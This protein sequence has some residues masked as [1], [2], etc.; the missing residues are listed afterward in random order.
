MNHGWLGL[1]IFPLLA[2]VLSTDRRRIDLKFCLMALGLQ[3]IFC[4]IIHKVPLIQKGFLLI[5]QG[6]NQLK[7]ATL[8]GTQFV[9]GYLGGNA[10]PFEV[11]DTSKLFIFAFQALPMLMVISAL[12]ML[13]FYWGVLPAIVKGF[14]WALRRTLKIGGALG[15]CAA[16]KAFLG[17]TDAPLLIR[18]YLARLS[19][20]EL[21]SVMTAGMATTSA[22]AMPLYASLLEGH[23][24][25]PLI[26]ILAA[27]FISIP[28]ALLMSRLVI[29]ETQQETGGDLSEPYPFSSSMDALARGTQ[30]GLNLYLSLIA[31]LIVALAVVKLMNMVLGTLPA[32]GGKALSL[33]RIAGMLMAPLTWA[34]GIPW[35]ES[36]KAGELLGTK[37]MLNEIIAFINFDK[38][39]TLSGHSK[40]MMIYALCGFANLSSI[41]IQIAGLGTLAPCRR[42]EIIALA[43]KALVAGTLASCL[44]GTIVGLVLS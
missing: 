18:P 21:F 27:S 36:F 20:S 19:K 26:H 9:F 30:D 29:P 32:L 44:S 2:W 17:Q 25:N 6:I 39:D 37:A 22:T 11:K 8:E 23:I 12:S 1:L 7:I 5:S 31:V 16:S 24:A 14:S 33:E 35:E 40:L 3:I 34:M 4:L 42:Q 41:G 43:P 38:A 28:G 13:L 15:V 10:C